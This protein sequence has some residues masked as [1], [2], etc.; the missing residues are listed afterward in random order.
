[1]RPVLGAGLGHLLGGRGLGYRATLQRQP[2]AAKPPAAGLGG[3]LS[4][5]EH[6]FEGVLRGHRGWGK[7]LDRVA[8]LAHMA[9]SH[10]RI[11][12]F[13]DGLDAMSGHDPLSLLG[14]DRVQIMISHAAKGLAFKRV[15]VAGVEEGLIPHVKAAQTERGCARNCGWRMS[16]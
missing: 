4:G 13:L 14:R 10:T 5:P 7:R 11:H 3:P 2:D 9:R 6:P 8:N 12:P 15:F 1:V 16:A